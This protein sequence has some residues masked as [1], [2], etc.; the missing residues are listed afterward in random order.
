MKT[1]AKSTGEIRFLR[2]IYLNLVK[3]VKC[4]K[5][6][7]FYKILLFVF[8]AIVSVFCRLILLIAVENGEKQVDRSWKKGVYF[9]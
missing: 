7:I 8:S 1:P 6:L 3:D 2:K 9:L 4:F 5:T